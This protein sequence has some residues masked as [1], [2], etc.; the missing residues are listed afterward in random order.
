[1]SRFLCISV[2][3]L[4]PL[5][6]GRGDRNEAE[7]PPSPMRLFQ[8][9]LNGAC[10]GG[11]SLDK[12]TEAAFHWL[13][14]RHHPPLIVTPPA[15]PATA[16]KLFVPNN[17]SDR[18]F[19]RQERLTEKAVRPHR[20]VDDGALHYL[21]E[22]A[23]AEWDAARPHAETL[24]REA[25]RLLTLGWGIDMAFSDG[26]VLSDGEIAVL[27]G[28]RWKA[29]PSF[30]SPSHARSRIPAEGSLRDLRAVH[31]SFL[32]SI[33]VPRNLYR[34][35][36]KLRVFEK[37]DYLPVDSLPRRSSVAFALEPTRADE[38][39]P[40]FPQMQA[41]VVAAMLRSRTCEAA[42]NDPHWKHEDTEKYV[43][44]HAGDAEESLPRFSYIPLPSV[45]HPHADGLI[46]RVMIAEPYGAIGE[47][48][49]WATR[50]LNRSELLDEQ[51]RKPRAVL[52]PLEGRDDGVLAT[53]LGSARTW[54]SVTPVILPG[55]DDHK[56][57]KAEK[58]LT[59]AIVQAGID[60]AAVAE[61]RLQKAPF[62]HGSQ[63]PRHYFAPNHLRN[64]PRWHVALRFHQP[65]FGPLAV[66]AGR[67]CGFGLFASS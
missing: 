46:R 36:E 60:F 28:I 49:R 63:H 37:A 35:P 11:R 26:R 16:H 51:T 50:R 66:G 67:H 57:A 8:A 20:L 42:K 9:L 48:S 12:S 17:D 2:T 13:E 43:A 45:G 31:Q 61:L 54:F 27:P 15:R 21:W 56:H 62:W 53:Y 30:S 4:D 6:H 24:C 64:F 47:H 40:A 29:W 33:D 1:M 19:D 59:K 32:T 22:I 58:L 52:A 7:W 39:S 10:V 25:R 18:Q 3:L 65:I 34:P 38:R 55:Q 5:F 23:D 14:K 41:A 44:G